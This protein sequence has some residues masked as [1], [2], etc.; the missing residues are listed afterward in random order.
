MTTL[1][2]RPLHDGTT[3][4]A[5]GFGTYPHGE[6]D[7][8]AITEHALELGYRLLDTALSYGNEE[9]VGR[10]I[11]RSAVPREEIVLTTK[12][13]GRHH[14]YDGARE[15]VRRSLDDLGLSRID[16]LLI[17]WP[18]PRLD[19]YVDTWRAMV[20][21]RDE[22]LARSIGVSNFTPAHIRRL[23]EETGVTP[24]VNQIEMHPYFHQRRQRDFHAEHGIVTESWSPLGRGG[25]LLEEPVLV[26]IARAHDVGVGQVV[27]RWHVEHGVVPVPASAHPDRRR[28]NREL[29]FELT[30]GE[31][32]AV[33]GLE[34][35]RIWGQDPD[36]YEEC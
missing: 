34:R 29:G 10:G 24:A 6:V 23:Q 5:V 27:L 21:M 19:R 16:L 26:E 4:P 14:G 33:D 36:E 18:L 1:P 9:A 13:P 22:G 20:E 12:I 30:P 32:A 8:A 2:D 31:V 17:H 15:S 7:S 3:L 28:L 11:A 35:G 25:D